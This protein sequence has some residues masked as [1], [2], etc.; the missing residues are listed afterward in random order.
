M[1]KRTPAPRGS[2][3][4]GTPRATPKKKGTKAGPSRDRFVEEYLVDLNA[5]QAAIRAGYSPKTARSQGARLLADA[6][7]AAAIAKA[8]AARAERVAL[9]QDYVL[10]LLH[11]IAEKCRGNK[12]VTI[13]RKGK[14]VAVR[15]FDQA[16]ANKA[17]DLLGKHFGMFVE[18]IGD[19]DGK[20]LAPATV[21]VRLVRPRGDGG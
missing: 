3:R 9:D 18:R 11:E 8:K 19:P 12:K 20:P 1:S 13:T 2:A 16:G 17:A 21:T 14:D 7:V 6:N 4:G 15:I 5:T 10:D